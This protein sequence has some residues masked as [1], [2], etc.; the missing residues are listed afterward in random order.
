M[1]ILVTTLQTVLWMAV[2]LGL[3]VFVHE[4]GHFLAARLF[5]MRVDAF[6]VGMPPNIVTKQV[7]ETEYRIGAIP[8]GGYVKIAGMVDESMDVPYEME[9][10]LDGDGQPLTDDDGEPL[11]TEKLDARGRPIPADTTPQPDEYRS[12]PVWQRAIVISAGVVFNVIFAILIYGALVWAYGQ[13]YTPS[14]NLALDIVEGS[15]AEAM[16]MQSGDRIV[17]VNG[18]DVDRFED[19]FTPET[20]SGDFAL[21]VLRD[22]QRVELTAD[23]GLVTELSRKANEADRAEEDMPA[24]GLFGIIARYPPVVRDVS[25]GSAAAEAGIR[26]GDRIIGLDST[27]IHSWDQLV[28][29]IQATGGETVRIRWARPDSLGP[30]PEGTEV[31]QRRA[32]ATVYQ[33]QVAARPS[34]DR[35]QLG[36]L[37]DDTVLGRRIDQVGPLTALSIGADQTWGMVTGTFA[38]IGKMVTGR[39][40]V[41]ENVGGPL[42]IAQQSKKAADL[43]WAPFWEFVAQISIALAVFNVLPIPALDGGHL[44]FLAYEGIVRREPSLKVRMVVQQVGVALILALMVFVIFNDAIRWFG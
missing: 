33:A 25:T 8:L 39:E 14:E 5:G 10:A 30:A 40:S 26:A 21:T 44:V 31:V 42:M 18:D 17:G 27:V 3:L 37:L 16:G 13:S 35:Y 1:D 6:S 43:G 9:P 36:V 19:V 34:G 7:G 28:D 20:L 23:D 15:A 11:W 4:M 32:A 29:Q 2:A 12:K 24:G 22:G 38:F 41:R